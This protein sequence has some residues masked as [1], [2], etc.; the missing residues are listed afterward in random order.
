MDFQRQKIGIEEFFIRSY[1]KVEAKHFNVQTDN[2]I[3]V[4]YFSK[5]ENKVKLKTHCKCGSLNVSHS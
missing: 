1:H 5:F 3:V 4:G 2:T